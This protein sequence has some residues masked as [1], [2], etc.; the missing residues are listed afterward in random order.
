MEPTVRPGP[1]VVVLG[2]GGTTE[3]RQVPGRRGARDP[4][5]ARALAMALLLVAVGIGAALV[6]RGDPWPP[7]GPVVGLVVLLAIAVNRGA[8]FSSELMA[9]AEAAVLFT[10]IVGFHAATS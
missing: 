9:T 8:F 5:A 6:A 4:F 1:L 10:A 7:A 3:R 2:D